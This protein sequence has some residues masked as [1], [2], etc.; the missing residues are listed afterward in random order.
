MKRFIDHYLLAWSQ[1]P[2]RKSL[3]LR[4]ARQVGKT[5][6]VRQLG[7]RFDNI[8]EINLEIEPKFRPFFQ[9]SLDPHQIVRDLSLTTGAQIIP[10]KT[11]LFIDEIQAEPR[12]I[13]A[14]RY[15]YEMMPELHVIAA[16]SLLDFAIEQVGVPVGRVQMLY[17]YPLSFLEFL[18]A[19]EE[20]ILIRALLEHDP[21]TPISQVAHERLLKLVGVYLAIGGMPEVV[22]KYLAN[23]YN[24]IACFNQQY[25]LAD[26][27]RHDFVKYSK[28]SQI[29]YLD[30]LYNAIPLQLGR[31]F[32]YSA[33]PGE[34]RKRELA[35]C[36]DLLATAGVIKRVYHTAAQGIPLG[37]QVDLDNFKLVFLDVAL[38]Q[39]VMRADVGG[40]LLQQEQPPFVNK[41]EIVE[42]FVGQELLAYANPMRSNDLYY[43]C[44]TERNSQAE[45]DYVVQLKA[46]IV[47]IEVKG[48]PGSTL[49]SM[50]GF[51]ESH[52]KSPYGL[53]FS[54]QN[55]SVFEKIHSYPLYAVAQALQADIPNIFD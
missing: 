20:Q 12:A 47:P 7:K 19:H 46:A 54:T 22:T 31:K 39:V 9:F 13:I 45:V 48:G 14:L 21:K 33:I 27:Y 32:K 35:P 38:A 24:P 34:Y 2:G 1:E 15:F 28:T 42:S 26:D 36:I 43:W 3:L 25:I 53:R 41:G 51:L 4:G 16:G 55:Y 30:I 29:K 10:G 5:Y 49:R 44:R 50:H 17:M 6:A 23:I 18:N 8:V 37:A 11:L 52:P 40:W